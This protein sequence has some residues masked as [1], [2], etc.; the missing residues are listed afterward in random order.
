MLQRNRFCFTKEQLSEVIPQFIQRTTDPSR[1][2][3]PK[4]ALDLLMVKAIVFFN[5]E[6]AEWV[7]ST[8]VTDDPTLQ[9]AIPNPDGSVRGAD[10]EEL[11]SHF[12]ILKFGNTLDLHTEAFVLHHVLGGYTREVS[13]DYEDALKWGVAELDGEAQTLKFQA[14]GGWLVQ[15]KRMGGQPTVL[16]SRLTVVHPDFTLR[17]AIETTGMTTNLKTA[18]TDLRVTPCVPETVQ[19]E[20][21][22]PHLEARHLKGSL[23]FSGAVSDVA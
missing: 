9:W 4:D 11:V 8:F 16:T 7:Q 5:L 19:L 10:T 2:Q 15:L 14:L 20:G 6:L 1:H 13:M 12:K 22:F 21:R 3:L 23:I 18:M 17:T